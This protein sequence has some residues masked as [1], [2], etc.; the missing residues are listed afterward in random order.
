VLKRTNDPIDR[1]NGRTHVTSI[2][3]GTQKHFSNFA[4]GFRH[5][6]RVVWDGFGP[7][8]AE[9]VLTCIVALVIACVADSLCRV[10]IP[11]RHRCPDS[12]R[13]TFG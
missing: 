10:P 3:H 1:V 12:P 9:I 5:R 7:I 11:P 4:S 8:G 2:R 13:T 6:G